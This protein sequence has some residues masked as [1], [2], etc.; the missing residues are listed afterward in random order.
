MRLQLSHVGSRDVQQSASNAAGASVHFAPRSSGPAAC[1]RTRGR[2]RRSR[3][4]RGCRCTVT[5]TG[6][7]S[8]APPCPRPISRGRAWRWRVG[9][10]GVHQERD[11]GEKALHD[12]EQ[13]DGVLRTNIVSLVLE[14]LLALVQLSAVLELALRAVREGERHLIPRS[15]LVEALVVHPLLAEQR[16][17]VISGSSPGRPSR[18]RCGTSYSRWTDTRHPGPAVRRAHD[19]I[20]GRVEGSGVRCLARGSS[21]YSWG[22]PW[23]VE[24]RPG[25]DRW[26]RCL[27]AWRLGNVAKQ[28]RRTAP[29]GSTP[30]PCLRTTRSSALM[31]MPRPAALGAARTCVSVRPPPYPHP[32]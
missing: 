29:Q 19:L 4:S 16:H 6:P 31:A 12:Q 14:V 9:V 23:G 1:R 21:Q 32:P 7:L 17:G 15:P 8:A 3:G 25:P 27:P 10:A 26:V 5:N 30:G 24:P 18:G 2:G 20:G 11:A 22:G 13:T 28:P